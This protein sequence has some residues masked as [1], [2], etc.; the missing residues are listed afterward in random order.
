[1]A[2]FEQNLNS[3]LDPV[4]ADA[5]TKNAARRAFLQSNDRDAFVSA[6]KAT[7][8]PDDVKAKLY[9]AKKP[10]FGRDLAGELQKDSLKSTPPPNA[11]PTKPLTEPKPIDNTPIPDENGSF[12]T[13]SAVKSATGRSSREWSDVATNALYNHLGG[14]KFKK[15]NPKVAAFGEFASELSKGI[16]ELLDFATS[17][18]G[19]GTIAL[20]A[21]PYTKAVVAPIAESLF[22]SGGTIGLFQ[23]WIK[24]HDDPTP[25][26]LAKVTKSVTAAIAPLSPA[27][28]KNPKMQEISDRIS[29]ITNGILGKSS[30]KRNI[31]IKP[32]E[33]PATA[34]PPI[35][36]SAEESAGVFTSRT[37]EISTKAI[38]EKRQAIKDRKSQPP[39]LPQTAQ[40]PP[41]PSRELVRQAP[42]EVLAPSKAAQPKTPPRF[43][44]GPNGDVI[45]VTA[46]PQDQPQ[47]A[48]PQ[49]TPPAQI[50]APEH[51]AALRPEQYQ[52]LSK[53]YYNAPVEL[54]QSYEKLDDVALKQVAQQAQDLQ[55]R[56]DIIDPNRLQHFNESANA[57]S[58]VLYQRRLNNPGQLDDPAYKYAPIPPKD[59]TD[60]KQVSPPSMPVGIK[61]P[62]AVK[63]TVRHNVPRQE[64]LDH[65]IAATL[66]PGST[67]VNPMGGVE[68]LMEVPTQNLRPTEGNQIF[69]E[70]IQKFIDKPELKAVAPEA[71][72]QSDGTMRIWDGHHRVEIAKANGEGKV[73]AWVSKAGKDNY[74]EIP[75]PPKPVEAGKPKPPEPIKEVPN[76]ETKAPIAE[77][78]LPAP[79]S[80]PSMP[81][82]SKIN[83]GPDSTGSGIHTLYSGLSE[84][85]SAAKVGNDRYKIT[86]NGQNLGEVD[87]SGTSG[88]L[89][90]RLEAAVRSIKPTAKPPIQGTKIE[91][92]I[93][94]TK[95]VSPKG[96]KPTAKEKSTAKPP[97]ASRGAGASD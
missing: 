13:D 1:M 74:P 72:A 38:E 75:E 26:N 84:I 48:P 31:T 60:S 22:A 25:A 39:P 92:P 37:P 69:P 68:T 2:D 21:N 43:Y 70:G 14:D 76:Y 34:Q 61:Q 41:L 40:P 47:I 52:D 85:G 35:T 36:K 44:N 71:R 42:Q 80:V 46:I 9:E 93:T 11:G 63:Q 6:I 16:P 66:A 57:A 81:V 49:G 17:P 64:T 91:K 5:A 15:D 86:L 8:I 95:P 96:S 32:A 82:S 62:E 4:T 56:G 27:L 24:W 3:I 65:K 97:I 33:I 88:P 87:I 12:L 73:L 55:N 77:K 78:Q 28:G 23:N 51:I 58:A 59:I 83:A 94:T 89:V 20:T 7:N 10:L 18:V 53:K 19:A 67:R 90:D 79:K 54:I 29:E 50:A 45:D 30:A